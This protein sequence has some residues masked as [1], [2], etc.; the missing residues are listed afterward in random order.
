M[1]TSV[2]ISSSLGF[3]DD[4]SSIVLVVD[5]T[6]GLFLVIEDEDVTLGEKFE[7]ESI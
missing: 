1:Q 4:C 3:S 2:L 5:L 7:S 6:T